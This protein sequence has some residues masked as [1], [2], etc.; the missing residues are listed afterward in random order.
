[1]NGQNLCPHC[2]TSGYTGICSVCGYQKQANDPN[3][4]RPFTLLK[5]RYLLGT[6]IGIGGFGITYAAKNIETG[7]RLAVKEYFPQ[8]IALRD[9][10]YTVRVTEGYRQAFRHGLERFSMEARVLQTFTN[11]PGIVRVDDSFEWN[12]T[13]YIVMEYLPG[14]T[15]KKDAELIGGVYPFPRASAVLRQ[16]ASALVRV[17]EVGLLHRDISPDNIMVDEAG[18][19]KLI[20][21][22]AARAYMQQQELTVMMKRGYAPIEQYSSTAAQGCYTDVYALGCTMYTILAG[23]KVPEAPARLEG[24]VTPVLSQLRSDLPDRFTAAIEKAIEVLPQNRFQTMHEFLLATEGIEGQKGVPAQNAV[25][26]VIGGKHSGMVVPLECERDY[27]IGRSAGSY[28][29]QIPS[30]LLSK[31]HWGVRYQPTRGRFIVWDNYSTNGSFFPSG[32]RMSP[33]CKYAAFHG[34]VFYLAKNECV[35]QLDVR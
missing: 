15:L 24:A 29:I 35:V 5:N 21:F 1:M 25:L 20:D 33:G 19:A 32:D 22:G 13:G 2:F 10:A 6:P 17:H 26:R 4:L 31:A 8:G 9:T 12:G 3:V 27:L 28:R 23:H 7:S 11:V 16:T 30:E 14:R 18:N 34:D